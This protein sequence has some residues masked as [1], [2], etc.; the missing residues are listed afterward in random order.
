LQRNAL[1]VAA[2]SILIAFLGLGFGLLEMLNRPDPTPALL[3]SGQSDVTA[4]V[5]ASTGPASGQSSGPSATLLNAASLG[6][7]LQVVPPSLG[8]SGT[9][10]TIDA[11]AT[12]LQ[13][14]YTIAPGDTLVQI[15]MRFNTTAQRIQAFNNLADPRALRI[16]TR[17]VIPPPL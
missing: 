6:S 2:A 11:R 5:T 10:R 1:S 15:A 8:T 14:N 12:V 4:A 9:S 3:V 7:T 17:L 16:G 13:P